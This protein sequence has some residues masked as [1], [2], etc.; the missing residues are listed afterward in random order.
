[1]QRYAPRVRT[2]LAEPITRLLIYF[3]IILVLSSTAQILVE[4]LFLNKLYHQNRIVENQQAKQNIGALIQQKFIF[5]ELNFRQMLLS[6]NSHSR[7]NLSSQSATYISSLKKLS[8]KH[9]SNLTPHKFYAF[10]HFSHPPLVERLKA[11]MK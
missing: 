11:L 7:K 6:D 1:M 2:F 8:K 5:L 4:N 10:I 9:L 3:M